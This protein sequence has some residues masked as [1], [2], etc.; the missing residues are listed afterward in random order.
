MITES[1]TEYHYLMP[2]F[3]HWVWL[4]ICAEP[5][6]A[7][8][9]QLFFYPFFDFACTCRKSEAIVPFEGRITFLQSCV[10]FRH[11]AFV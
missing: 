9:S 2:D 8:R 7:R 5:R 4:I 11:R 10:S 3:L 6:K 1:G